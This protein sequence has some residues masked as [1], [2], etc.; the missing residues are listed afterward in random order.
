METLRVMTP[1]PLVTRRSCAAASR[2]LRAGMPDGDIADND[3]VAK[4]EHLD[5]LDQLGDLACR[6][7]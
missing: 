6:R 2:T 5:R 1:Y 3:T 4:I 7:A